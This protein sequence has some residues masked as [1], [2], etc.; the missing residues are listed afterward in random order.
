MA[1]DEIPTD[2]QALARLGLNDR[3][4]R[5]LLSVGE[6][7]RISGREFQEI[8]PEVSP[9]TLRRDLADL[10]SRGLLL[11]VGERRATYFI[12]K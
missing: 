6:K 5:A 11:K 3:Q 8:C 12:L 4:V 9:E 7:G 10:V 1:M 2:P